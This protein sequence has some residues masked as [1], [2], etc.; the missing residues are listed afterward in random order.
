MTVSPITSKQKQHF[1]KVLTRAVKRAR[2]ET[3][4]GGN[5]MQRL[6]ARGGEFEDWFVTGFSRFTAKLPDYT[7]AKSIL[8]GDFITAEEIMVARPDVVYSPEQVT[9]LAETIPSV[10]VLNSLKASGYGLMPQPP[11][12]LSLLSIRASK[13]T[14][15][16]SKSGGWYE[17][18]TFAKND[19]TGTGWLAI[20]KTP[21]NDSVSKN[22]NEQN[23]LLI[24]AEFV[25]NAAETSWFITIFFDIRGVRLFEDIYIRT[26]SLGSD[27]SRVYIGYFDARGLSINSYW[28][29]HRRSNLGLASARK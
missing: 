8:G 24:N 28:D 7:L 13:S 5:G 11:S 9:Q 16:Y 27:G 12:A 22:W 29:S 18:Q 14:H 23:E 4:P 19:M 1:E 2:K 25:P 10:D 3:N 6:F 17:G 26:S 21:A 15:F 20:K